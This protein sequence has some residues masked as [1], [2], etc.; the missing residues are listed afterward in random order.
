MEDEKQEIIE[1]FGVH[2]EQQYNIAP[3]AARVLG[4]LIV[5]GCKSGLTF[6]ALVE[7]LKAS[8]SSISTNLNLLQKMN[9]I[10]YFTVV[11]DRKKYFKAA[12]LSQRLKNYLNLVDSEKLLI[13]RIIT[14]R[15]KNNSCSQE[16]V[17]L[18]N[19]YAYKEHILNVE[20][21]LINS[22]NKFKEIEIKNQSSK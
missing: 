18:Q 4:V 5:D 2:F 12:P 16:N 20:Q 15:E 6:E 7:K 21:L 13:E 3:L 10:D 1:M 19:S 22:I 17:N 8:K 11:G 9:L 14:Y